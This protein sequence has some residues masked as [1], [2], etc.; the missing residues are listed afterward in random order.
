MQPLNLIG[1]GHHIILGIQRVIVG[2]LWFS[3]AWAIALKKKIIRILIQEIMG[4]L[5]D[6][7]P[8]LTC[9]IH[10]QGGCHTTMSM[11][12]PPSGSIKYKASEQDIE[13]LRRLRACILTSLLPGENCGGRAWASLTISAT[14]ASSALR[15]SPRRLL[16]SSA[17][18]LWRGPEAARV[19]DPMIA[20]DN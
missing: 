6:D 9:M 5:D 7:M 13:L 18:V 12:K 8:D 2:M 17:E 3:D 16:G 11:K 4:S 1:S 20:A 15:W 10:W 14:C 19:A